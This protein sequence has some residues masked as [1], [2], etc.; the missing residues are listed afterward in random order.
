[1][2]SEFMVI[3]AEFR[4]ADTLRWM[5]QKG[6]NKRLFVLSRAHGNICGR[7]KRWH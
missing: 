2:F 6:D 5:S 4:A 3:F 7:R 1:M